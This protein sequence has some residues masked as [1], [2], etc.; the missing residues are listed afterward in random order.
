MTQNIQENTF[1][2]FYLLFYVHV[3]TKLLRFYIYV[4]VY[5]YFFMRFHV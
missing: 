5:M 3:N 4:Y 2:E 1:S